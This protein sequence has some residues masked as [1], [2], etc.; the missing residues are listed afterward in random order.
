M[1]FSSSLLD[2]ETIYPHIVRCYQQET[3]ET[4]E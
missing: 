1:F 4:Y 2:K 3:F